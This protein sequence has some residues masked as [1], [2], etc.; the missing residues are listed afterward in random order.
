MSIRECLNIIYVLTFYHFVARSLDKK[1]L[2]IL[3]SCI[4]VSILI[5]NLNFV[6]SSLL[7]S[8][9]NGFLNVQLWSFSYLD[10]LY[11]L[12]YILYIGPL[13]KLYQSSIFIHIILFFILVIWKVKEKVCY[14]TGKFEVITNDTVNMS[15]L[16]YMV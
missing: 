16:K 6:A 5:K 9:L 7:H 15:S 14:S 1:Y 13:R 4:G 12:F 10:T 3:T 11:N 8:F 2:V